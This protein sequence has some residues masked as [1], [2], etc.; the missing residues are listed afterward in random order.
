MNQEILDSLKIGEKAVDIQEYYHGKNGSLLVYKVIIYE[1]IR[2]FLVFKK[3]E[4]FAYPF[5]FNTKELAENF[6]KDIDKFEIIKN[7]Y[8]LRHGTIHIYSLFPKEFEQPKNIY[9][10]VDARHPFSCAE[11]HSMRLD[12]NGI[13]GGLVNY[14]TPDP[15]GEL[16]RSR[17]MSYTEIFAKEKL[18]SKEGSIG[19]TFSYKLTE[20]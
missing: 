6:I 8:N 19:Q 10:M 5:Y 17:N 4:S 18:A 3:I 2:K 14:E 11:S 7:T 20:V 12:D 13:W 9:Y 16:Y 1:C 15:Y